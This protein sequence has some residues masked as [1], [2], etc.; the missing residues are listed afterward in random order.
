MQIEAFFDARTSTLT[1]V[2]WDAE[3]RDAV[4]IDPVLDYE[5]AAS[6][7]W[8]ESVDQ[9][10]QFVRKHGLTLHYIMETHAHADHLSG[11]Q[12]LKETFPEAKTVIGSR[13][14]EVQA[15][16]K[17]VFDLPPDFPTDG[18][19]FDILLENG[20]TLTAGALQ[21]HT[22]FTPGHTPACATFRI[23]DALF[24]GDA[25]FMPD[26]GTGRCDF[27]AGSA[28]DLYDSITER[29]YTLPDATRMF[30]GHD[31]QPGGRPLQYETTVGEQKRSNKQLRA[32]T[33]KADFV[34]FRTERDATLEAPRL[35]F[36]SVQV[37]V[38]AGRLPQPHDNQ[39][40]YLQ[41]PINI[42]RPDSD[43]EITERSVT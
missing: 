16:F 22:L 15:V 17:K 14:T 32:D 30:V 3:T 8:T 40:R 27:P 26:M 41:I 28:E 33:P 4:A 18:R 6:K 34:R 10:V 9:V 31:Y 11:S 39:V 5:P 20:S 35:L 12:L 37:N 19:Q 36:Q 2:V 29:I 7:T 23:E 42:F 43:G 13:I 24:T 1:Y 25:I 38:D 21:I